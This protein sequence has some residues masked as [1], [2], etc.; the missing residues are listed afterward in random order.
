MLLSVTWPSFTNTALIVLYITISIT[1]LRKPYYYILLLLMSDIELNYN[2]S[3]VFAI[4]LLYYQQYNI[5]C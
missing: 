4:T 1:V 3:R 5:M 2:I